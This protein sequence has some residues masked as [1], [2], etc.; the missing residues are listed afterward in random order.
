MGRKTGDVIGGRY[1]IE[2]PLGEG[3]MAS[4]YQV[5]HV[6]LGS[7]HAVKVLHAHLA[8]RED[9]RLRFLEEG[10]IQARLRHPN[11]LP[12]TD[13]IN[14]PGV[15]G[16]VMELLQGEDLADYLDREGSVPVAAAIDWTLQALR[17]LQ[18]VHEN[19]V[20][21]R[22][23]KPSNLFLSRPLRGG[24]VQVRLMDFGIAK[25]RE[26]ERELTQPD[27]GMMGTL[28]Y[29]SPEQLEQPSSV[30][31]RTDIFAMGALLYAMLVGRS[32][33][34]DENDFHIMKRITEGRY[35]APGS[36]VPETLT[37]VIASALSPALS[38]RLPN[39]ASFID[40]LEAAARAERYRRARRLLRAVEVYGLPHRWW[41]PEDPDE[42]WI[43]Q[44]E[45]RL[46]AWL[47]EH[48]PTAPGGPPP[49]L[50]RVEEGADPLERW[51]L[52][53]GTELVLL[54]IT[55]G[56]YQMGSPKNEPHRHDDEGPPRQVTLSGFSLMR[57]PLTRA[58]WEAVT[59]ADPSAFPDDP[60][61]P[62]AQVSWLDAIRFANQLSAQHGLKAAYRFESGVVRWDRTANGFR[63]PTEA[64]WEYACRAGTTQARWSS[65]PIG[66]VAWYADNSNEQTHPVGQKAANPWGLVDLLGNVYEW[67]FDRLGAYQPDDVLE[68]AGA[69]AGALRVLRG[70]SYRSAANDLRAAFRNGREPD[71][72]HPS[73]GLRLARGATV[74]GS[75][76]PNS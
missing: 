70:G 47:R 29:M 44:Q 60:H 43:R 14:E 56:T 53:G 49:P 4:V 27:G 34:D 26:R 57:A 76:S 40:A 67:C 5:R 6:T 61:R 9:V 28:L 25:V 64:E 75:P 59:G 71:F 35:T 52:S 12:V 2:A 62:V 17:A 42:H 66:S 65:A 1:R 13:L 7:M 10:K 74:K 50:A 30:D 36:S 31:Q 45:H 58:Q 41:L 24:P 3:G 23:L 73:V 69:S 63:L 8:Q 32:P 22:D 16:L 51:T 15:A 38:A 39:A 37:A 48:A 33:F 46:Q 68:P 20:V 21:H 72:R 55:G 11:I 19:A 54:P 18:F